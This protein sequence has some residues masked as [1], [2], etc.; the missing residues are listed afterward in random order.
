VLDLILQVAEERQRRVDTH[1]VNE[2]LEE[3]V[4]RQPPPH[5]RGRRV[6]L[7]Y[8][9]QVSVA[10]P[11]FAI[12]SNFPKAVPEHYVRYLHNGFREAW[13]FMGTP[14]RL[15]VRSTKDERQRTGS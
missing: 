2:I 9:T 7:R 6:R 13:T 8:A 14:I 10:P 4:R 12:F 3:L 15:R 11:T 5:H 1:V